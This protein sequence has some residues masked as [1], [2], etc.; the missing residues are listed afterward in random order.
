[1]RFRLTPQHHHLITR[2]RQIQQMNNH[3][4]PKRLDLIGQPLV[5]IEHSFDGAVEVGGVILAKGVEHVTAMGSASRP[6]RSE[7][8]AFLINCQPS[9]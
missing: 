3:P 9:R 1:M 5:G 6:V 7:S 4:H 8:S 2:H